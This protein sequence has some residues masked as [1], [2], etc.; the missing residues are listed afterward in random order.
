MR[1]ARSHLE[2]TNLEFAQK[3]IED[4]EKLEIKNERIS[5]EINNIK[6]SIKM[7]I[8]EKYNEIAKSFLEKRDFQQSLEYFNK[9]AAIMKNAPKLEVIKVYLNRIATYI[10][11][12]Q[13]SV[14]ESEA[15]RILTLLIKQKRLA[16]AKGD[17]ELLQKLKDIEVILYVRKGFALSKMN[18]ILESLE[19]YQKAL[20]L[21]PNDEKIKNNIIELKKNL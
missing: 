16:S 1:R 5:E 13:F 10:G 6:E 8:F 2:L 11:M 7:K 21:R 17:L 20:E 14:V 19:E 3:D 15:T 9:S 18:R 4:A 12:D